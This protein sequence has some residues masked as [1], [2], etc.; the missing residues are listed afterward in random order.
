M[1]DIISKIER[2][3]IEEQ[4]NPKVTYRYIKLCLDYLE[5]QFKTKEETLKHYNI[6]LEEFADKNE[7][8]SFERRNLS[9]NPVN[10]NL[11]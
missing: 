3:L 2:C 5:L 6:L 9:V 4:K 1:K 11:N 10:L 7:I 8:S